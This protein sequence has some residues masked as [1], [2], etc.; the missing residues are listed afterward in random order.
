MEIFKKVSPQAIAD[1]PFKLIGK[2]WMLIT[3]GTEESYN[4]MTG[5]WGGLGILWNKDICF[6]VIRPN[7]HTYAFMEQSDVFT[8]SF[9]EE[10]YRDVLTYCGSRSGRD[11]NK[12]AETGLTPVF[13]E[14]T[15]YFA[16][17]RLVLVCRKVYFQDMAPQ[18]FRDPQ[19]EEFYPGKDYHRIYVG[20]ILKCLQK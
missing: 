1:N 9:L 15:I 20:E 2:D 14:G 7:R 16:E 8:L 4:T 3:A 13:D 17:A 10:E 11:V 18:N 12:V 6:C 5:A 19:M